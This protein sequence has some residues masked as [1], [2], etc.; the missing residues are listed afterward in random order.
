MHP[1]DSVYIDPIFG[2]FEGQQAI[3]GWLNDV[4][5]KMGAIDFDP[6][7]PVYWNGSTSLQLWKQVA[8]QPDGQRIEMSWGASVRRFSDGWLTYCAD[9][10]DAFSMQNPAVQAA[11]Q[12]AGSTITLEDI[13]RYRPE[14]VPQ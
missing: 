11:G 5:N 14:L 6:I 7:S 1:T 13:L 9:Y 4:M 12:A 2:R 3:R 10:F 8:V